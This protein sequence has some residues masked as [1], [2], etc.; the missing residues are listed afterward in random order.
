[1]IEIHGIKR[2]A[3]F[4][5]RLDR[6]LAEVLD[7]LKVA[8]VDAVAVFVDDNGPKGGR[9]LRCTLTVRVPF[10]PAI[11][12]EASAVTARLAFD[13]ALP[14]LERRLDKYRER[15]LDLRRRP[16]KYYAARRAQA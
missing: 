5:G 2:D 3:A 9:A 6:R 10:K 4:R 11:R 8:P 12:V 1:M 16:K 7:R 14:A 13:A 15:A